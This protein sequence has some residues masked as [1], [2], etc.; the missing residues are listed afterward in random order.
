MKNFK[1]QGKQ[2]PNWTSLVTKLTFQGH[3][4]LHV[5]EILAKMSQGT[6]QTMH[7]VTKI[8][9]CIPQLTTGPHY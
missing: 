3:I 6:H 8:V 5:I 9:V 7:V 2:D 4:E 1:C